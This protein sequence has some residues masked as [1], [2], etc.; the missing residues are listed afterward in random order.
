MT[1]LLVGYFLFLESR[2]D[3]LDQ[4]QLRALTRVQTQLAINLEGFKNLALSKTDAGIKRILER[5]D[6]G[7]DIT[8]SLIIRVLNQGATLDSGNLVLMGYYLSEDDP[9]ISPNGHCYIVKDESVPD[10]LFNIHVQRPYNGMTLELD[11]VISI[12]SLL[13]PLLRTDLFDAFIVRRNDTILYES[14]PTGNVVL[15]FDTAKN[16]LISLSDGESIKH[17]TLNG[18]SQRSYEVGFSVDSQ[19]GWTIVGLKPQ[20]TFDNEKRTLPRSYLFAVFIAG[21]FIVL[22]F[23]FIKSMIM[24]RTERLSTVDV[25]FSA[26]SLALAT[27]ILAILLIDGYLHVE[28]DNTERDLQ[29]S[30][31]AD[32]VESHLLDEVNEITLQLHDYTDSVYSKPI[33]T[34]TITVTDSSSHAMKVEKFVED[35]RIDRSQ[36]YKVSRYKYYRNMFL[37][38]NGYSSYDHKEPGTSFNVSKRSYVKTLVN[39]QCMSNPRVAFPFHL[40]A[41]VSWRE[42]EFRGV[43]S[44]PGPD[45]SCPV[46]AMTAEFRTINDLILPDDYGFAIFDKNGNVLFHSEKS[47]CLNENILEEC[48]DEILFHAA[49]NGRTET[50][51][52]AEYSGTWNNFFVKPIDNL[53]YYVATFVR[54]APLDAVHGQVF[55]IAFI[56]QIL[57]FSFYIGVIL[58]GISMLSRR[59]RLHVPAIDLSSFIPAEANKEKYINAL[60]FNSLHLFL[61]FVGIAVLDRSLSVVALL[62][63]AAPYTIFLNMV[64]LSKFRLV[65]FIRSQH[66]YLSWTYVAAIVIANCIAAFYITWV[67]TIAI[68][69]IQVLTVG[70]FYI[71]ENPGYFKKLHSRFISAFD[72]WDYQTIYHAL[73]YVIVLLACVLPASSFATLAYD[74]E[75]E[76]QVK[77]AQLDILQDLSHYDH[78]ASVKDDSLTR[79]SAYYSP[80]FNSSVEPAFSIPLECELDTNSMDQ[81]CSVMRGLIQNSGAKFNRLRSG[82][83]DYL[84]LWSKK[85]GQI[86]LT[87]KNQQPCKPDFGYSISSEITKYHVPRNVWPINGSFLRFWCGLI[88]A[89]GALFFVLKFFTNKI[90]VL[91]KYYRQRS[92]KYD[93]DFFDR[94]QPGYKAFVTGMP[95][96][97]KSAYFQQLLLKKN[98]HFIDFI[99]HAP[100]RWKDILAAADKQ[101]HGVIVLD[102]FEHDILDDALNGKKLELIESLVGERKKRVIIISSIQPAVFINMLVSE[103]DTEKNEDETKRKNEDLRSH[104][105]WNR[106]LASF[107]SF[108]FPLQ[109]Y[110]PKEDHL[111]TE[112]AK[113]LPEG[114][115]PAIPGKLIYLVQS[116]C[117]HGP[118]MR[119]IG[120]ELLAELH[121]KTEV[122]SRMDRDVKWKE[123]EDIILRTQKLSENYYRSLWNH[124]A[125]EEQFVLFDLAQDGLV[126]S[127]NI[128]IVE[129]LIDKGVVIYT[130]KLRIMNRSFRNFILTVVGP[131]DLGHIDMQIKDAGTWGKIKIPLFIIVCALFLFVMESDRS[132]LFGYFTAFMAIIPAVVTLFGYF[133]YAN[134]KE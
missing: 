76:L 93:Q 96:A 117:D 41:I 79:L 78:I 33:V 112:F 17:L 134:R 126:N 63:V 69:L 11:F 128:D 51:F 94:V 101:E 40:D 73:I 23:P 14:V 6:R 71:I 77:I 100:D 47:R 43:V 12:R 57:L 24:S 21:I 103:P 67:M 5:N 61:L 13:D 72:N 48:N 20:S 70:M 44:I 1:F 52:D 83:S 66:R 111:S 114:E 15:E 30:S 95:S 9:T 80:L 131:S 55:G 68:I 16:S 75:K 129:A 2:A 132:A 31:M 37:V 54:E 27:S 45:S 106:V 121:D 84:W 18:E 124:L 86:V 36:K 7:E 116:E 4:R 28:V 115:K 49:V 39:N 109:G 8:E 60:L 53:P 22:S 81:F 133:G 105:R 130:N 90:F 87:G 58:I 99:V 123:R 59:S 104:E 98:A 46:A 127:K 97:G 118:F 89:I 74:K 82:A 102:H 10:S 108:I 34:D 62:F 107:Y 42:Q 3:K 122:H 25:L 64:F 32:E 92:L 120:M 26:I 119:S 110:E 125:V 91:Q 65:D 85:N 113:T 56:L 35:E 19:T 29:L 88:L 50:F 38:R